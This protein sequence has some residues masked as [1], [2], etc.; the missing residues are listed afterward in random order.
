MWRE[1][2]PDRGERAPTAHDN[3]YRRRQTWQ[4]VKGVERGRVNVSLT[5]DSH[6]FMCLKEDRE[7]RSSGVSRMVALSVNVEETVSITS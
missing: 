4:D 7:R 1:S 6:P 5:L 3:L 2:R